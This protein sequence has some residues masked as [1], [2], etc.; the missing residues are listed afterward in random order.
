MVL[1]VLPMVEQ[2]ELVE[3]VVNTVVQIILIM[4]GLVVEV[5]VEV[6]ALAARIHRLLV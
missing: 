2:L 4:Y 5:L 3:L 1:L 6:V